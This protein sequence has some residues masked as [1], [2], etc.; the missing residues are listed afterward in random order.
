MKRIV[1]AS[2]AVVALA[3]CGRQLPEGTDNVP[4]AG[5]ENWERI[6]DVANFMPGV[7]KVVDLEDGVICYYTYYNARVSAPSCLAYYHEGSN[8]NYRQVE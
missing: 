5:Q 2:L 1:I 7:Y 8:D 3:A 6:A 4:P